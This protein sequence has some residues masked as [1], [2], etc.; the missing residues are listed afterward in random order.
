MHDHVADG[1]SFRLVSGFS[2]VHDLLDTWGM[3]RVP[4]VSRFGFDGAFIFWN[5]FTEH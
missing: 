5:M 3:R 1:K 2:G 4:R